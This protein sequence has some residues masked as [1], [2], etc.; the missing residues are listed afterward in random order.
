MTTTLIMVRLLV[1][2]LQA[3][4]G[5]KESA[6][7]SVTFKWGRTTCLQSQSSGVTCIN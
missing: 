2:H 3:Q 5:Q 7:V 1:S 4:R 6:S